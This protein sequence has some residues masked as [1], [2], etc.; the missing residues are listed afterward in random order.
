MC[1]YYS[2]RK[3]N[4]IA[5]AILT[6]V[7]YLLLLGILSAVYNERYSE[8]DKFELIYYMSKILTI[9]N[10]IINNH[11][12][13]LLDNFEF[14]GEP[15]TSPN[16]YRN[17]LKL[18]KNKNNC[19]ENYRPCGL[20]DTYGNVLC[21]EEY[22]PCPVNKMRVAH[23]N[24][25]GDYLSKN[26]YTAPLS[27]ISTNYQFFYSNSFEEGNAVAIIIK[28]KDEP[29]VISLNNFV[30]D[31]EIY[32]KIFGDTKLLE[33][34]ADFLGI[35]EEKEKET[36][37]EEIIDSVIKI[38]QEVKDLDD[39]LSELDWGLKGG[40]LLVKLLLLNYDKQVE[41]FE[42]FVKEKI[43]I[44]DEKNND[45]Y[46]EHIGD[47][48]YSKNYIGFKSVQDID[49]FMRFDF[50]IYKKIFPTFNASTCA[51]VG[52]VCLSIIIVLMSIFFYKDI[53]GYGDRAMYLGLEITF[54][55]L[56]YA[57]ALGFFIYSLYA[58]LKVTRSKTLDDLKSIE[59]DEYINDMIKDFIND[60][61]KSSLVL[62][63]ICITIVSII[64]NV[65]SKIFFYN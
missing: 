29:K 58:Y 51:L 30:L 11:Y 49:K 41:K 61:Q 54:C 7:S 6:L 35:E 15:I 38:F 9:K 28:T 39:D 3:K 63:T 48:F 47:N 55:T 5:Y 17:Y 12:S 43:Q 24:A 45:V 33:E 37:D 62:S 22:I 4:F 65:I 57:L 2:S 16:T 64:L 18:V 59:S 50:D 53:D 46:Y 52:I 26:Y 27:N 34:I 40:K 31:S 19:I 32:E 25:A 13:E 20:L 44:M 36:K 23:K 14:S 10:I 8:K 21:I 60:C 42:K 56:F 1:S